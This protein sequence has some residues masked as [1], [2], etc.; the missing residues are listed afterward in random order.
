MSE[1]ST[2][3]NAPVAGYEEEPP[4]GISGL[5]SDIQSRLPA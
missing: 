4:G 2:E 3:L 5:L 1:I